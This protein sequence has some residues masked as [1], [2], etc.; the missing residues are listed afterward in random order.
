MTPMRTL[1]VLFAGDGTGDVTSADGQIGCTDECS[2]V[3]GVGETVVLNA[4]AIEGSSFGG[5]TGDCGT[6]SGFAAS[7]V[8]G[9][10]T[11]CTATFNAD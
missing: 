11:T 6:V 2:A 4:R 3:F 8:M 7:I 5:Y 9:A 10:D 1:T